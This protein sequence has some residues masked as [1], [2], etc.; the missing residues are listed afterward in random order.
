MADSSCVAGSAHEMGGRGLPPGSHASL[1]TAH[2]GQGWHGP[3]RGHG[4]PTPRSHWSICA[5]PRAVA[6]TAG[7]TTCHSVRDPWAVVHSPSLSL[8]QI[9]EG[10]GNLRENCK[11]FPVFC[12]FSRR[13]IP[14]CPPPLHTKGQSGQRRMQGPNGITDMCRVFR[15]PTK[16]SGAKGGGLFKYRHPTNVEQLLGIWRGGRCWCVYVG[17]GGEGC[18]RGVPGRGGPQGGMKGGGFEW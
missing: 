13:S 11:Q 10:R 3:Y 7:P 5:H 18:P 14:L 9:T 4:G 6:A 12:L 17:G 16:C 15:L 8:K 2:G 1:D